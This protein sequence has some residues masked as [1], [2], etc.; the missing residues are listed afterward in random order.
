MLSST[1]LVLPM[2][3]IPTVTNKR[4]QT[5]IS[6]FSSSARCC[7]KAS[8]TQTIEWEKDMKNSAPY[9]PTEE[10][11]RNLFAFP[12]ASQRKLRILML[13]FHQSQRSLRLLYRFARRLRL[14]A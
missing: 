10:E 6:S 11:I 5:A 1:G 9:R 3:V 2:A 14:Q 13:F 12:E 4:D 8:S 7:S